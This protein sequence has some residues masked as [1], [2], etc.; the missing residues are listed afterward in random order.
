MH[1]HLIERASAIDMMELA[2]ATTA[3]AAQVGT[4][5]VLEPGCDDLTALRTTM[6]Q[7]I[8]G[9]PRLRQSLRKTPVGCGRPIWVDDGNFD[10]ADHV[11]EVAC[12][13][14]GDRSALLEMAAGLLAKPLADGKPLWNATLVTGLT[15]GASA[16]VIVFHHVLADGMGG[17]AVLAQLLDGV[18]TEVS[19]SFPRPAPVATALF[20]DAVMSRV[21]SATRI[22]RMVP[23]LRGAV[24]ELGTRPP[25]APRCS[26]NAPVG[27]GRCLAVVDSPL[28]SIHSAA[29]RRGVSVNDAALA[30]ITGS[31]S[32]FLADRGEM[33]ERFVVSIPVSSR[34][35][36][37]AGELG[38]QLGFMVVEL[39]GTG[40]P[41]ER[42]EAIGAATR[43]RKN[44]AR[45]ASAAVLAP[46]FRALAA[47]RMLRRFTDHQHMVNTFVT[48]LRGPQTRVRFLDRT[49][50]EILPLN[51][52]SGNVRVAF[53]L[54]S[55]SGGMTVTLV[56]DE[57][58]RSAL[59][60][61]VGHLRD[62]LEA[63]ATEPGAGTP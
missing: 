49:V 19:A 4:V 44:E 50:E 28:D 35:P 25:K 18:P 3:A 40:T 60:D 27:P 56:A 54:F 33:V 20:R 7:R 53:G 34:E 38:N 37:T 5:L 15:A 6:A 22:D 62:E 43:H 45:G 59:G 42:M 11:G 31:L 57:S 1:Q 58:F 48:N 21:R 14:P 29:R 9:V 46:L 41:G 32:R 30:A 13:P 39:P 51:S 36:P 17:L 61:L 2:A 63:V 52:T 10:I 16:V 24:A 55:Y 47:M 23:V 12:R 26:L 8:A